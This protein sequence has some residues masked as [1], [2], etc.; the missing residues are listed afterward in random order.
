MG[1]VNKAL[2]PYQGQPM[3]LHILQRAYPLF[4]QIIIIANQNH[5]QILTLVQQTPCA[6]KITIHSDL[7]GGFQGPLMGIATGLQFTPAFPQLNS[8]HWMHQVT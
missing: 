4:A 3:L 5:D 7:E 8:V 6:D 2:I 1:G